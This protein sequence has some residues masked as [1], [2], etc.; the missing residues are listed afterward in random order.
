MKELLVPGSRIL[1][2]NGEMLKLIAIHKDSGY[3]KEKLGYLVRYYGGD[4][5]LKNNNN[6]LIC[7]SIKDAE[8][9]TD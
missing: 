2:H 6:L 5:V 1:E 3:D 4:K 8:I 7:E 9:V